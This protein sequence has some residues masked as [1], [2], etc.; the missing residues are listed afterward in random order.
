MKRKALCDVNNAC[1]FSIS[2][3]S[4]IRDDDFVIPGS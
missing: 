1:K 2:E 4:T 3:W